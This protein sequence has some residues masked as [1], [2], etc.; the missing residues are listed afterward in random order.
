[1]KNSMAKRVKEESGY[2]SG[3]IKLIDL[4]FIEPS[5]APDAF[6]QQKVEVGSYDGSNFTIEIC[7]QFQS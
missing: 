2:Y 5:S 3:R 4:E 6:F 7:F 1:M